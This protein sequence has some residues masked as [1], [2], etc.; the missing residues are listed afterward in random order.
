MTTNYN[1]IL[2]RPIWIFLCLVGAS[3]NIH[4]RQRRTVQYSTVEKL[5]RAHLRALLAA[6][7][8]SQD[9]ELVL[10]AIGTVPALVDHAKAG[11]AK[12]TLRVEAGLALAGLGQLAAL[13][14]G[15]AAKV[16]EAGLWQAA[17]GQADGPT[18][19]LWPSAVSRLDDKDVRPLAQLAEDLLSQ[20][21]TVPP[22]APR[23][24]GPPRPPGR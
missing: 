12:A 20:V 19:L 14:L 2:L 7:Q 13:D 10:Q 3:C 16:A 8:N 23:P 18:A 22:D 4:I 5:K 9:S 1:N 24:D 15:A 6:F 17:L 21:R 11:M